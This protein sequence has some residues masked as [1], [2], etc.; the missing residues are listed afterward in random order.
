VAFVITQPCIGSKDAS[1]VE[2]C[3]V[4]CIASDAASDQYFINPAQCINCG[5]CVDAC[6]VKA[7]HEED[8]VPPEWQ[9]FVEKN[10]QYFADRETA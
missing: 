5:A 3:P 1:C 8:D 6:P 10:A 2:V 4:D 9:R 7:I